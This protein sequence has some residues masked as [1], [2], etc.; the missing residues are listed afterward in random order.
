MLYPITEENEQ[1]Y[2]NT[3][4]AKQASHDRAPVQNRGYGT[5][6]YRNVAQT[7]SWY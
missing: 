3:T 2:Q 4:L 7:L 1:V 6:E 5:Q